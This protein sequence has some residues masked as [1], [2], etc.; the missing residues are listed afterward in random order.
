[1]LLKGKPRDFNPWVLPQ[2]RSSAAAI[3]TTNPVGLN[4]HS[5]K[6]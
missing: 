3:T 5:K 1:M 6:K 4:I 2:A